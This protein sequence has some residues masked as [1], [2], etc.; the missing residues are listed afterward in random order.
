MK[1]TCEIENCPAT[2]CTIA[3]LEFRVRQLVNSLV[4]EKDQ[5]AW[6]QIRERDLR[7][8]L[9]KAKVKVSDLELQL[10]NA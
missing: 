2:A 9:R 3:R 1:Q 6:G 7:E 4:F 10:Q 8:D 5:F